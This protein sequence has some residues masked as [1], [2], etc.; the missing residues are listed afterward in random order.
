MN[1]SEYITSDVLC[2]KENNVFVSLNCSYNAIFI[3]SLSY[4]PFVNKSSLRHTHLLLFD[5]SIFIYLY[6]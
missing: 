2:T 1:M 3:F 6:E 5:K 4:S